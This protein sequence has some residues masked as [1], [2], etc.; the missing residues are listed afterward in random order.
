MDIEKAMV[1]VVEV[2]TSV[3]FLENVDTEFKKFMVELAV[4]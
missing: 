2:V 1:R 4:V 3:W